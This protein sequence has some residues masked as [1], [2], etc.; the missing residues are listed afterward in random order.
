MWARCDIRSDKEV[1]EMVQNVLKK[2]GKIDCLG[3][4]LRKHPF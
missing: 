4:L 1:E 3:E 2:Y